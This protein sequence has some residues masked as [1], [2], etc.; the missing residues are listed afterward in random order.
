MRNMQK[1]EVK[2]EDL[3][4]ILENEENKSH[5]FDDEDEDDENPQI[6]KN[7]DGDI[8]DIVDSDEFIAKMG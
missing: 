7:E 5:D 4:R 3:G 2:L 6:K 8:D 1:T